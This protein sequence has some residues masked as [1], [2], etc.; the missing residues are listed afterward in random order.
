MPSY[1]VV[2]ADYDPQWPE[3]Y[4]V[5]AARIRAAIAG[6]LEQIEHVGS[7]AVPGLAAKPIIDIAV[8]VRRLAHAERCIEPLER[9]GYVYR[10]G[11][12][13]MVPD[14]RFFRKGESDAREVHLHVV[15]VRAPDWERWLLF[16]DYLRAHPEKAR[17]YEQLKR[18][19]V[20]CHRDN[21][22][23]TAQ[24]TAFIEAAVAEARAANAGLEKA[25]S[26]IAPHARTYD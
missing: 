22:A 11:A 16:R 6:W 17:E 23:Y 13:D 14:R 25:G 1:A 20:S 26:R 9:I 24:K 19:L 3:R 12:E 21:R 2:L 18:A 4:Q 7:T 10:S 15:E 8:G 5:E